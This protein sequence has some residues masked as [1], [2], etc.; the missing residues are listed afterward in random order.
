MTT[1]HMGRYGRIRIVHGMGLLS[2]CR[3]GDLHS[4]KKRVCHGFLFRCSNSFYNRRKKLN[5][6]FKIDA[7][8]YYHDYRELGLAGCASNLGIALQT[9]SRWQKQLKNN[10]IYNRCNYMSSNDCEEL[11]ADY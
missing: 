5:K 10:G 7:V 3:F 6:Q 8:Q 11:Y 1:F 2:K 4:T 9:L